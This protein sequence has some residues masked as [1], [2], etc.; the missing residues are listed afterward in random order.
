MRWDERSSKGGGILANISFKAAPMSKKKRKK[1][2]KNR[3]HGERRG[4]YKT[5]HSLN[6][7]QSLLDSSIQNPVLVLQSHYS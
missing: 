4:L 2:K 7:G 5:A 6:S 3:K 1:R